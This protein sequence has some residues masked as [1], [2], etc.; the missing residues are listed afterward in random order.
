MKKA[1]ALVLSLMMLLSLTAVM[2]EDPSFLVGIAQFAVHG[3]LDNC[4]EGF[5]QGM[6]EKGF[7]EG[8]N[9][10]Y[11][12][13]NAQADM[14]IAA[15]IADQFVANGAD[16]ILAIATPM[17]VVSV[18]SA[19]GKVPVVYSAV[20]SPKDSGLA[21]EDGLGEGPVTGTSDE[22][23]V[24]KQ[25]ELI[26]ALQPDAKVIGILYTLSETN[27][28]VQVKQYEA[29]AEQYG[30]TIES[31]GITS[32][33]EVAL[34]APQLLQKADLVTMVLDNTVVQYL[35]TVLDA[36]EPLGKPVYGSEIEQVKRGCVAA[37]GLDY[38]DLGR[39]TGHLAARVLM[40]E[41]AATIP[42]ETIQES[43]VYYNPEALAALN[44]QLPADLL[45]RGTDVTK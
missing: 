2:A 17:A 3:S 39:Q 21:T 4:R 32:G 10:F 11:D 41:D 33:A 28:L 26:R 34:A 5:I 42:F 15:G 40:G 14:G 38:F 44:I 20:S 13:Q 16:M 8:V 43:A 37:A 6:K 27:S 18:N 7:E 1:F 29:A 24:A 35:D 23:P 31:M 9:V 12:Y 19:D 45:A 36:A 25:L 30:F 22:L